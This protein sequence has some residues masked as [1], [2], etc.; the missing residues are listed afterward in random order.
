MN[1]VKLLSISVSTVHN[2]L[3]TIRRKLSVKKSIDLVRYALE[4]GYNS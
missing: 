1:I 3:A 4:K 2:H